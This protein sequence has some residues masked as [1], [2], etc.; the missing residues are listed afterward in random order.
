MS[1]LETN[2]PKDVNIRNTTFYPCRIPTNNNN[3]PRG[4]MFQE[5]GDNAATTALLEKN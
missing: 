3:I 2:L 4:T 5:E 1:F